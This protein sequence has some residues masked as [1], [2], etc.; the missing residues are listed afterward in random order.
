MTETATVIGL[1]IGLG[2]ILLG[3]SLEGG[4]IFALMQ[5]TA[6]FIVFGGTL[7]AV[8]VASRNEDLR[9]AK[10]LLPWI[11][12]KGVGFDPMK[13]SSEIVQAAQQAKK[14]SLLSLE[15][16]IGSY[17][18]GFLQ[19]ALRMSV[20]NVDPQIIREVL[21]TDISVE[22]DK[23]MAGAKVWADAGG[24]AP[25]I[26]IIGAVLG[27]IAVMNHLTDTSQLG[28]GIAVAFVATIYGVASANLIFLPIAAKLKRKIKLLSQYKQMI[29]E[30]TIAI[31]QG[32]NPSIIREIVRPFVD[33]AE[34]QKG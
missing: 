16:K 24:F 20:D 27:L 11:W 4:S 23:L 18:S 33:S 30:G 17:N 5:G 22:E 14:E 1:L 28:K 15:A 34:V 29:V 10:Q 2:G 32:L 25:T 31:S 3:N 26:G 7:G 21:E 12:K 6:G 9:V 8:L 19:K 13:V